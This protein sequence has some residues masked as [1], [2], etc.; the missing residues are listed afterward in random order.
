MTK[1]VHNPIRAGAW[2]LGLIACAAIFC[3]GAEVKPKE[4]AHESKTHKELKSVGDEIFTN[5]TYL[6]IRI[7]VAP[8]GMRILRNNFGGWGNSARR[9]D[10]K[11][12]A[13]L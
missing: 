7:E 10:A 9:P 8:E 2:A 1:P 5:L 3:L 12:A 11:C 6:K 13:R 4:K